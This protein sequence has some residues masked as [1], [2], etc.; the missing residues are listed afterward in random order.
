MPK[1]QRNDTDRY[2]INRIRYG[3][4]VRLTRGGRRIEQRFT[5]REHGSSAAALLYAQRWRDEMLRTH[6]PLSRRESANR[7]RPNGGEIPGVTFEC[8]RH[9]AIKLWRA[10]TYIGPGRVLQKTFSIARW[11]QAAQDMAVAERERQL[12]EMTGLKRVHPVEEELRTAP[13]PSSAL[14]AL[15]PP[16]EKARLLRS[17]NRSGF[18][19]VVLRRGPGGIPQHWT[20][21]STAGGRWVSRSFSIKTYGE[22]LALTLAILERLIQCDEAGSASLR[23]RATE[24]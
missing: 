12:A 6:P 23:G 11:G 7:P 9:G 1:G 5:D 13:P 10:K 20:A 24:A 14:P 2:A 8:D 22:P 18:A 4:A 19:G 17:T 3:W 16:V 21:Q 15:D